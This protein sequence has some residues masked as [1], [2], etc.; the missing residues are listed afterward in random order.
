MPFW[1]VTLVPLVLAA[2]WISLNA[3]LSYSKRS[4]EGHLMVISLYLPMMVRIQTKAM[5]VR[6][7]PVPGG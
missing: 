5:R 3:N 7:L 4:T 2:S 1:K 6:V